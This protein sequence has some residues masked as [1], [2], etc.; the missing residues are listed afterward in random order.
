MSYKESYLVTKE[1]FDKYLTSGDR[2]VKDL[3]NSVQIRQLNNIQDCEKFNIFANDQQR[4]NAVPRFKDD[5][6]PP[7]PPN[8]PPP[9]DE[10]PPPQPPPVDPPDQFQPPPPPPPYSPPEDCVDKK[11]CDEEKTPAG[12]I[13]RPYPIASPYTGAAVRRPI[14]GETVADEKKIAKFRTGLGM[15]QGVGVDIPPATAIIRRPILGA[16]TGEAVNIPGAVPPVPPLTRE[17]GTNIW[18]PDT[19]DISTNVR[20]D[21]REFGATVQPVVRDFG[22]DPVT[23]TTHEVGTSSEP[24]ARPVKPTTHEIGTDSQVRTFRDFA[25]STDYR[26]PFQPRRQSKPAPPVQPQPPPPPEAAVDAPEAVE[27]GTQTENELPLELPDS[28]TRK[29]PTRPSYATRPV[30]QH[31]S[32]RLARRTKKLP[33]DFFTHDIPTRKRQR[34]NDDSMEGQAL[35]RFRSEL[36]SDTDEE[37]FD[38]D[39]YQ[40]GPPPRI[41]IPSGILPMSVIAANNRRRPLAIEYHPDEP[42]PSTSDR[43]G[44]RRQREPSE[45][46]FEM[47]RPIKRRRIVKDVSQKISRKGY[48]KDVKTRSKRSGRPYDAAAGQYTDSPRIPPPPQPPV[49]ATPTDVDEEE[50]DPRS[51]HNRDDTGESFGAAADRDYKERL[52]KFQKKKKKERWINRP[53]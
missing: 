36:D 38:A 16:Y 9:P 17:F 40:T 47:K 15:Y 33:S 30:W 43:R 25:T 24:E 27:L 34:D 19:R 3:C 10:G 12:P 23:H 18:H 20:P 5:R 50:M 32:G 11:D 21:T 31:R 52:S 48:V 41:A 28:S 1:L 35:A 53:R 46:M 29:K 37:F 51:R 13:A 49:Q 4:G 2:E 8:P 44:R 45:E 42:K 6:P 22:I 39:E 7:A 26:R 14:L